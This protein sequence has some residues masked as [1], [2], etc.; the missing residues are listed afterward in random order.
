MPLMNK[1]LPV[2]SGLQISGADRFGNMAGRPKV[3]DF[4]SVGLPRRVHEHNVLRLQ[5]GV[6]QPQAPQLHQSC[7]HLLEHRS[8]VF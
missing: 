3:N 5:V 8:D 4:D 2:V 1:L 7:R 6:D